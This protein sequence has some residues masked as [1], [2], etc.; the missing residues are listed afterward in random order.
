MHAYDM[1]LHIPDASNSYT[2]SI[3]SAETTAPV[4]DRPGILVQGSNIPI[5]RHSKRR[6]RDS[7]SPSGPYKLRESA[8][9]KN[10]RK[11]RYTAD[12]DKPVVDLSQVPD[13]E[14]GSHKVNLGDD[15][16]PTRPS[17]LSV[18]PGLRHTQLRSVLQYVI[19]EGLKVGGRPES[20]VARETDGGE[21]IEVQTR[22]P[23]GNIAT[24]QVEWHI[25]REV[26]TSILGELTGTFIPVNRD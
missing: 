21:V 18:A 25:D 2:N 9:V 12:S 8:R 5:Q 24:K 26:P 15:I 19:N 13:L 7:D 20:A 3:A 23:A 4:T 11:T 10:A 14:L 17:E 1:D 6:R 22:G 16:S